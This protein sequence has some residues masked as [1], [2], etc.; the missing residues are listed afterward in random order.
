MSELQR[1][2]GT[3]I[4]VGLGSYIPMNFACWNVYSLTAGLRS[5]LA[6]PEFSEGFRAHISQQLPCRLQW[7]PSVKHSAH[8][9]RACVICRC[10]C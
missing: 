10:G 8:F 5:F 6:P 2:L 1:Q 4:S 7:G 9:L 3:V